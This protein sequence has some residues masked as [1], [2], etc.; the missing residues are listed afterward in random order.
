MRNYNNEAKRRLII[1]IGTNILTVFVN[2]GIY[3]WLTR[4]WIQHLG[5]KAY[6]MIP[7]VVSFGAYFNLFTMSI[8][9]A[10]SRFVAIHLGRDELEQSNVYF[11]SALSALVVLCG[12][13]LIP[14][15]VLSVSLSKVFQVPAGFETDTGW[16]FFFVVSS[17][18]IT[19]ATSPFLVSTF[20]THRFDLANLVRMLSYFL[21]LAIIVLCFTYLS[22][23]LKYVGLSYF[24]VATF[25]LVC[26]VLL[27]KRLTPQLQ[28]RWKLFNRKALLKIGR[29]S[30]WI[31]VNQVGA[32]LYL[33]IGFILINL[34]LG[35][36][37]CGRYAP[38]ALWVSLLGTLGGAMRD[39]F[40]PIAFEYIAHCKLGVLALQMR[41]STKFIGL[42]MG[43]PVGLLCGLSTPILKR[44][45][46]PSFADLGPLAWLLVGP[47]LVNITIKPMFAIYRGLDKVK[48]PAIVTIIGGIINVLLSILLVRYTD[49]GIY[50]VALSLSLCLT[51]KNLFFTPIYAAMI[52]AQ[53]KTAFIREIF[54]GLGMAALVSL[55]ALALSRMYALAAIPHLLTVSVLMIMVYAP[56]CYGLILNKQERAL[57]KS[58]ILRQG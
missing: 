21:R 14:A 12:L 38:I 37:Q 54:P 41:R 29:M 13:L 39:V 40:T 52:T 51:L 26:S 20:V 48:V 23:L 32:L 36:E 33:S 42:I 25:V 19:A 34:F 56:L 31:A 47:W 4:Y 28:V 44:W 5:L 1:N 46:G 49:L 22:P 24:A 2:A 55:V 57:L 45:L 53:H 15:I 58:M 6:G 7:F 18:F 43:F 8:S 50:G 35:P 17:S 16:L 11:N 30:S 3:I 9:N 10:V 27:T